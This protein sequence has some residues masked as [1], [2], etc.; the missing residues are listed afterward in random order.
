MKKGMYPGSEALLKNGDQDEI[1][2][3]C[4][5]FGIWDSERMNVAGTVYYGLMALQ[6]RGQEA[7]GIAVC[8]S[9]GP[10][11]NIAVR[12]DMGLVSEVFKAK[13][14]KAMSGNIGIGH[15]RYSTT[16]DSNLENAQPAA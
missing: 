14:L 10:R 13:D 5:V 1:H 7:A 6:H 9:R 3:E 12:K 15:V 2:E 11:G 16:G 4:G 8:D